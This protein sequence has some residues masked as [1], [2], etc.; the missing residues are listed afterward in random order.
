MH[1]R[2][3][4]E[5]QASFHS[6]IATK[7][8]T[9]SG[10]NSSQGGRPRRPRSSNAPHS[11]GGSRH[12]R[13]RDSRGSQDR[14]PAEASGVYANAQYAHALTS[15]LGCP[16]RVTTT[17]N[18]VFEG[19]L[20]AL[21]KE[22]NFVL[23]MVHPLNREEPK[24]I[25]PRE[26]REE[27]IFLG[28]QVAHVTVTNV[29]ME[30]ATKSGFQTDGAITG[31]TNGSAGHKELQP[32]IADDAATDHL[33]SLDEANGWDARDM[34][35]MNEKKYGVRS[36]FDQTLAG[37]TTPLERVS[38]DQHERAAR[39]AHEIERSSTSR[40]R[41]DAENGDEEAAFAAVSRPG[42]DGRG[43][44]YVP[45]ARRPVREMREPPRGG[46]RGPP[47]G[48]GGPRGPRPG[49]AG[50]PPHQQQRQT[51][52]GRPG[53]GRTPSRGREDRTPDGPLPHGPTV[54]PAQ[55][56]SRE[57]EPAP[58]TAAAS[59][60]EQR[61][62]PR[63][64]PA[65]SPRGPAKTLAGLKDFQENFVLSEEASS[66]AAPAAPVPAEKQD[67][68]EKP[69]PAR[70]EEGSSPAP[71]TGAAA[72]ETSPG[73]TAAPAAG[74]TPTTPATIPAPEDTN[75]LA[76]S[77]SKSKLNPNAKEFTMNPNAKAFTP[78]T[79]PTVS[80]AMGYSPEPA[81]AMTPQTA[82]LSL[83]SS[84]G[85]PPFNYIMGPQS[86]AAPHQ[87]HQPPRPHKQRGGEYPMGGVAHRPEAS[88]I[89]V[90]AVTGP[91][92][93]ATSPLSGHPP[94]QHVGVPM[95]PNSMMPHG[96]PAPGQVFF[97][98]MPT[99]H[100]AMYQQQPQPMPPPHQQQPGP[101]HQQH[102]G[103]AGGYDGQPGPPPAPHQTLGY[104]MVPPQ[105]GGPGGGQAGGPG[106]GGLMYQ[107]AQG[108]GGPVY[109]PTSVY[110]IPGQP[111]QQMAPQFTV[112]QPQPPPGPATTP[113]SSQ[114]PMG[115]PMTPQQYYNFQQAQGHH[116]GQPPQ[117]PQQQPY[118]PGSGHP[119]PLVPH[120]NP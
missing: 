113:T 117:P 55:S 90:A 58:E 116:P 35:R 103:P 16:V 72:A 81:R 52:H 100:A 48:A 37:Y 74:G 46:P 83:I 62:E 112:M 54:P 24:R 6:E 108:G 101:Q 2:G 14:P 15:I 34:F 110:L 27:C 119:I 11:G 18:E 40:H 47:P 50:G 115:V 30:Y 66:A 49:S 44:R 43:D 19:I 107:L 33:V 96:Y 57:Q 109:T 32:W 111:G 98:M 73:E 97:R 92:L 51:H 5:K 29:D 78:F 104:S 85:Q 88:P 87:M 10:M 56:P 28:E 63:S 106:G 39:I 23:G 84:P 8:Y 80:M 95:P 69:E 64:Q 21:S 99:S 41:A 76:E 45:P 77:L 118:G 38:H 59:P 75:K 13:P 26:V 17:N 68:P 71:P 91:P 4:G 7:T 12:G 22:N 53:S 20:K 79:P 1:F 61:G 93:M 60:A 36:T 31:R 105:A 3:E 42:Q 120:M 9:N 67:K 25:D 94:G 70:G 102:P 65:Q 86:F 89:Q 114:M 82:P